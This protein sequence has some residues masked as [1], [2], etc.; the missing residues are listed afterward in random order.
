MKKLARKLATSSHTESIRVDDL[1]DSFGAKIFFR[2][3]P[4]CS[5]LAVERKQNLLLQ[6]RTFPPNTSTTQQSRPSTGGRSNPSLAAAWRQSFRAQWTFRALVVLLITF[7]VSINA[8]RDRGKSLGQ[9]SWSSHFSGIQCGWIPGAEVCIGIR[10]LV[11]FC[12][13][14]RSGYIVAG[15]HYLSFVRAGRV[16]G[17][18]F[19]C[20]FVLHMHH[21]VSAWLYA[22]SVSG[23]LELWCPRPSLV[24]AA[25]V[26]MIL[27]CNLWLI[28]L[29][30][31]RHSLRSRLQFCSS[32]AP[33]CLDL[34]G[35]LF[36][37]VCCLGYP[38]PG[39]L[40]WAHI[41]RSESIH[42]FAITWYYLGCITTFAEFDLI[43]C[44]VLFWVVW[45][46]VCRT[47]IL[48]CL[49]VFSWWLCFWSAFVWMCYDNC[50]SYYETVPVRI[51]D[52]HIHM[53]H[54]V[55]LLV[56][57]LLWFWSTQPCSACD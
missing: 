27:I 34:I 7:R 36:V 19:S 52:L 57:E 56:L 31:C 22:T 4:L 12:S 3:I 6:R 13:S 40:S 43:T 30:V 49:I 15:T 39:S 35:A 21:V 18:L 2:T 23:C 11:R 20:N 25:R 47:C 26:H 38:W 17:V 37:S 51:I 16:R 33:C 46:C 55:C 45:P 42:R 41:C 8:I 10:S 44:T 24:S 9:L 54:I 48:H 53:Y 14:L 29:V 50:M 32:H 28:W 1:L 5:R